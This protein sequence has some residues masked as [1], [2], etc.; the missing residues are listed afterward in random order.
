MIELLIKLSKKKVVQNFSFLTIS[1]VFSQLIGLFVVIKISRIFA[2]DEYGLYTFIFAQS[3]MI[4][5]VGDLGMRNII[6]R[7]ISRDTSRTNDLIYNGLI[8]RVLASVVL[9]FIY[10]IY[11][12]FLGS[13][14]IEQ[15]SILFLFSITGIFSNLFENAFLGQQKMLWPSLF[16]IGFSI[17]WAI[18]IFALPSIY[19]SV[20]VLLS[21]QLA[22][23][24][25]K[26]G[27]LYTVMVKQGILVGQVNNFIISSK[28][29][30]KESWP[31]FLLFLV[32]LPSVSFANNF[33]DL[34]STKA[35]IGYFNLS[36]KLM[37]P[38]S[39]VINMALIS[40][41]PNFSSLWVNDEKKFFG[42]ISVG[43][44]YFILFAAT[45]C[46]LFTLFSKEVVTL[47]FTDTYLP[48]IRVCQLQVWY[49]FLIGINSLIGTIWGATNKEKLI[50]KSAIVNAILSTPIIYIGSY[51]GAIG[52]SYGYVISFAIFEIYLWWVFK[53]SEKIV[54]NGDLIL[55]II[56][57]LLFLTSYF[58]PANF[59]ITY[60]ILFSLIIL[61]FVLLHVYKKYNTIKLK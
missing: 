34:N 2:P 47:L 48:A 50:L 42:I 58:F 36:Q 10:L 22:N 12:Y 39:L 6:V 37:G 4:N 18:I 49:V 8:L 52:L 38:V 51:Y 54:I 15:I 17:I 24:I 59:P 45:L 21:I 3:Q 16:N 61:S 14:N 7:A 40:I 1:S 5:A 44:K 35:E 33:L 29:I 60:K 23:G 13:L 41:F 26:S 25:A 53:K 11:N 27:F 9:M 30:L 57:I 56:V 28:A 19:F 43:F 46:F 20:I 31:Y 55:W 32:M